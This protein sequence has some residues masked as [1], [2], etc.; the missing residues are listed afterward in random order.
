MTLPT[1][2]A[3]F[4]QKYQRKSNESNNDIN[5]GS[6]KMPSGYMVIR[7]AIIFYYTINPSI[8]VITLIQIAL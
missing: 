4:N 1:I 8:M 7:R 3:Q 6:K 5:E 2:I